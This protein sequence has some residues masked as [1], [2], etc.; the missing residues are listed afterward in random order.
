MMQVDSLVATFRV[1]QGTAYVTPASAFV[2]DQAGEE[3]LTM[4]RLE[5]PLWRFESG[6]W[7]RQSMR[8]HPITR[9][10]LDIVQ[11][12]ARGYVRSHS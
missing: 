7:Y 6:A 2:R 11:E 4:L 3:G 1:V 9:R 12:L 8:Q 5:Q 10:V